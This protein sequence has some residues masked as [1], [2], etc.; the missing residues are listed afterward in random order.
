MDQPRVTLKVRNRAKNGQNDTT[1]SGPTSQ[2]KHDLDQSV[3]LDS[4]PSRLRVIGYRSQH[5]RIWGTYHLSTIVHASTAAT[6]GGFPDK[7]CGWLIFGVFL[8]D[9]NSSKWAIHQE[10]Y[11]RRSARSFLQ[12]A[13]WTMITGWVKYN[14]HPSYS[15][16]KRGTKRL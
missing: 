10:E 4:K 9:S 7:L 1:P 13:C 15:V 5:S 6:N 2:D 16:M 14:L 11:P 12:H 8:Q 3:H